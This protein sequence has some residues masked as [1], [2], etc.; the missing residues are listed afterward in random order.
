[1]T[2]PIGHLHPEAGGYRAACSSCSW[3]LTKSTRHQAEESLRGH[4]ALVHPQPIPV[5]LSGYDCQYCG[6]PFDPVSYRWLCPHCKGKNT[7][8]E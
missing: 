6:E 8:C 2:K 5:Y 7:C 3:R 4:A 1:M